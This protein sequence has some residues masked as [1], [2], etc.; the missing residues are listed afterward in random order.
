[1]VFK[2]GQTVSINIAFFDAIDILMQLQYNTIVCD[3]HLNDE[4]CNHVYLTLNILIFIP[5]NWKNNK[6]PTLKLLSK[7]LNRS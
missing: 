3:I 5:L 1:L 2:V 4:L 6:E 7:R